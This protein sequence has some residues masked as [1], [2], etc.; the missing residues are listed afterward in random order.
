MLP[1]VRK[2]YEQ[3]RDTKQNPQDPC[4]LPADY[5]HLFDADHIQAGQEKENAEQ[6]CQN[7]DIGER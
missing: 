6:E 4:P 7:T 3:A 2:K 1:N 5:R